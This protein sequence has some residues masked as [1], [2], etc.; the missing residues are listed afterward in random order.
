M[1]GYNLAATNAVEMLL[2]SLATVIGMDIVEIW[3]HDVSGFS[4]IQTLVTNDIQ[5]E[6]QLVIDKY[7]REHS[8][9]V[10]SRN[11]CKRSMQSKHGFYWLAKKSQYLHPELPLHTAIA[12]HL[13]R[14]NITTDV[15]LISYSRTYLRVS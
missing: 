15:F 8:E 6:N 7:H 5:R 3:M 1:S 12:F 11:L 14:D 10:T 13:P 4:L 9:S 2:M